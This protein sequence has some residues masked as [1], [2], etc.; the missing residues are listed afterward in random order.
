MR[1]FNL[2]WVLAL[3]VLAISFVVPTSLQAEEAAVPKQPEEAAVPAE[4]KTAPE[5]ELAI[6]GEVKAVNQSANSISLQYYDY[7]NDEEKTAEIA[8]DKD[9]EIK[10][11]AALGDIKEGD[12]VDVTYAVSGG[13]NIAKSITVEKEEDIEMLPEEK[14]PA[15]FDEE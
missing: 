12:W 3:A 1:I 14:A 8:L 13:K 9:T 4:T 10:N 7:D 2:I 15:A 6:Y 11:V 5:Q